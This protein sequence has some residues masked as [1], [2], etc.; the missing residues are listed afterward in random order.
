MIYSKCARRR[1]NPLVIM[2]V[3]LLWIIC[4]F[5][6]EVKSSKITQF[7][8]S[9]KCFFFTKIRTSVIVFPSMNQHLKCIAFQIQAMICEQTQN[10]TRIPTVN[11]I[12]GKCLNSS[13]ATLASNKK[14]IWIMNGKRLICYVIWL[15][16]RLVFSLQHVISQ[17][18]GFYATILDIQYV[19]HHL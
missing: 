8:L 14:R 17:P 4:L 10:I 12:M 6:V 15:V 1:K 7:F 3:F 19:F 11:R 2:S 16:I 18:K 9:S 13:N 5:D